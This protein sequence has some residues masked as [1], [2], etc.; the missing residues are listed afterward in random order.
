M[1]KLAIETDIN[2]QYINSLSPGV[3]LCLWAHSNNGS[4]I[5]TGT[6][7]GEKKIT[8]E[9]LGRT[10]AHIMINYIENKIPVD[11]YLSD[12]LI[13]LMAYVDGSSKIRVLEI[14]SHTKTNLD[15]IQMFTNRKYNI[16]KSHNSFLIELESQIS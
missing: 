11:N 10:A 12:Q 8:S 14:T 7:L 5:S 1:R 2:I 16:S 3:G 4:I 13:P 9:T 6:I 15:L